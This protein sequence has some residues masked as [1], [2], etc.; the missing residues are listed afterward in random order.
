MGF[1]AKLLSWFFPALVYLF[2]CV[3]C[4]FVAHLPLDA[5]RSLGWLNS[6]QG[7]LCP[8][9]VSRPQPPVKAGA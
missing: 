7:W 4:G 2:R 8:V 1:L 5:A 9:C 6:G 3:L